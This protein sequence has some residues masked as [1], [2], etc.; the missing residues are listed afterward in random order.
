MEQNILRKVLPNSTAL[1][2]L[3][4]RAAREGGSRS[5]EHLMLPEPWLCNLA[6]LAVGWPKSFKCLE[7][8]REKG[9]ERTSGHVTKTV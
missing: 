5:C 3:C 8:T 7:Y 4:Q 1:W 9:G 6:F 2:L